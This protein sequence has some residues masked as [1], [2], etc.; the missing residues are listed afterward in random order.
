ML[1][2]YLIGST[3]HNFPKSKIIVYDLGFKKDEVEKMKSFCHVEYRKFNFSKYP[4]Y[5][6]N[7]N[8]YRW[9]GLIW[10]V[11]I[12]TKILFCQMY[13]AL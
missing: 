3:Q 10:A 12:T 6:Q 8:Q 13:K 11:R 2:Q 7:L 9:K 5:V 1:L 4:S